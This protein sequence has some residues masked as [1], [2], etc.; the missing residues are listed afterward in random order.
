M[1]AGLLA[2]VGCVCLASE[3]WAQTLAAPE[4]LS[5][6]RPVVL[7]EWIGQWSGPFA[8]GG[9][10]PSGSMRLL[11]A[12]NGEEWRVVSELRAEDAPP[13]GEVREWVVR[14]DRVSYLQWYN[15]VEVTFRGRLVEG[16]LVGDLEA[17]REGEEMGIA[18]Y[19]LRR[20]P[21]STIPTEDP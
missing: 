20:D 13:G 3:G 6:E 11:I 19:R 15:D 16:E 21:L 1:G 4:E 18:T 9:D 5:E 17:W 8:F 2:V 14:G 10:G 7:E 12:R